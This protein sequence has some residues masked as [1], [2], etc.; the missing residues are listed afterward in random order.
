MGGVSSLFLLADLDMLADIYIQT[1]PSS[2]TSKSHA[3]APSPRTTPPARVH[4]ART[5]E[6][7]VGSLEPNTSQISDRSSRL[8]PPL[9][10]L[11][12]HFSFPNLF[13][14]AS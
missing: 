1:T 5:R 2:L 14:P 4:L 11:S 7:V 12:V 9:S 10:I 6:H 8:K 13:S 3:L